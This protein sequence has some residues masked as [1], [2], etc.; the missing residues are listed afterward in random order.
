LSFLFVSY[1]LPNLTVVSFEKSNKFV[2][3]DVHKEK[4]VQEKRQPKNHK[5]RTSDRPYLQHSSY[6]MQIAP[7][8]WS[9]YL[10]SL[11]IGINYLQS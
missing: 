10:S 7:V 6:K 4:L 8:T 2:D 9:L 3:G 5:K 1:Q 11:L